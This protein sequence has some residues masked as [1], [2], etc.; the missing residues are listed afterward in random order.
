MVLR[1]LI[2]SSPNGLVTLAGGRKSLPSMLSQDYII[3]TFI[4]IIIWRHLLIGLF[5]L[6]WKFILDW[7]NHYIQGCRNP[8]RFYTLRI[9]TSTTYIALLILAPTGDCATP[10][11]HSTMRILKCG[12]CLVETELSRIIKVWSCDWTFLESSSFLDLLFYQFSL[13]EICR[14]ST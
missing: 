2:F 7:S 12:N 3:F 9:E 13:F 8:T 4:I 5:L 11:S 14:G 6:N 10:Y 1:T